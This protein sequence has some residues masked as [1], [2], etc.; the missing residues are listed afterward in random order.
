[1]MCCLMSCDVNMSHEIIVYAVEVH[2]AGVCV[3][4]S[5]M[6]LLPDFDEVLSLMSYRRMLEP[7]S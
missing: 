5:R 4:T 2:D 1:M 7:T 3:P 6:T